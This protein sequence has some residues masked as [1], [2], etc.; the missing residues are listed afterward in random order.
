MT[1]DPKNKSSYPVD[2]IA[3]P[4]IKEFAA[5]IKRFIAAKKVSGILLFNQSFL[6]PALSAFVTQALGIRSM[7]LNPYNFTGKTPLVES[8][9]N[10]LSLFIS[11]LGGNLR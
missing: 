9:K 10:E 6:F 11:S 7:D 2:V 8:H 3:A 5:E 1:Y 4:L